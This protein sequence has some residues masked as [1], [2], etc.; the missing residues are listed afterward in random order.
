MDDE[1][2]RPPRRSNSNNSVRRA[3]HLAHVRRRKPWCRPRCNPLCTAFCVLICC[4]I[5][6]LSASIY[7]FVLASEHK[8]EHLLEKYQVSI[9]HWLQVR[10]TYAGLQQV[11][12]ER[13][14]GDHS[15]GL[16]IASFQADTSADTYNDYEEKQGFEEL[17]A[18]PALVYRLKGVP[19][20]FVPV[21]SM[22]FED[23][24]KGGSRHNLVSPG[25]SFDLKI[26]S[27]STESQFTVGPYS[28]LKIQPR[29]THE[30]Y[31][32]E[33]SCRPKGHYY[34]G[35]CWVLFYLERICVQIS[36]EAS[37]SGRWVPSR[38]A[39]HNSS[40]GCSF[41][42]GQWE[43]PVY[44]EHISGADVVAEVLST[45]DLGSSFNG[46]V[47]VPKHEAKVLLSRVAA[48][49]LTI[50]VRSHADPYL[51]ALELTDG[52]LDFGMA[53]ED[54]Q[55][56]AEVLLVMGIVCLVPPCGVLAMR[57]CLQ[58]CDKA[59]LYESD[60]DREDIAFRRGPIGRR[61]ND[62]DDEAN[63]I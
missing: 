46:S 7:F 5:G 59:G 56:W 62:F 50:E 23:L 52:S 53:A 15:S 11:T 43:A 26:K 49:S 25:D 19:H 31:S 12:V 3:A 55:D 22:W 33:S 24:Y 47:Y 28:L 16:G 61:Y 9:G 36:P 2:R 27:T 35:M 37:S 44:R 58:R 18:Y 29:P 4:S 63:Q 41:A 54:E 17:P 42:E 45:L 13:S 20:G 14:R 30:L 6:L 8:R 48:E 34:M 21:E 60:N 38:R 57:R 1:S 40:Y 10:P 32:S 51:T 39:S